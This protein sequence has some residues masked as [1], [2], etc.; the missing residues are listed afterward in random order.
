VLVLVSFLV[1]VFGASWVC[2]FGPF[3]G[4]FFGALG[5]PGGRRGRLFFWRWCWAPGLR[6]CGAGALCVLSLWRVRLFCFFRWR[7]VLCGAAAL[8]GG[9]AALVC[10]PSLRVILFAAVGPWRSAGA[11]AGRACFVGVLRGRRV[12]CVRAL[13]VFVFAFAFRWRCRWLRALAA[14]YYFSFSGRVRAALRALRFLF[15]VFQSAD[16]FF[17]FSC[18]V[19]PPWS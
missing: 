6:A 18:K 14:R 9:G 8:R 15:L 16:L 17:V 1:L 11:G 5:A 3:S 10:A 2:F 19:F 12:G 13:F 7:V 4:S